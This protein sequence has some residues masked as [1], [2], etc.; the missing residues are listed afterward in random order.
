ML[1]LSFEEISEFTSM[2]SLG[3][4]NRELASKVLTHIRSCD[5]CREAVGGML[6]MTEIFKNAR[7]ELAEARKAQ[8]EK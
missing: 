4:T 1:H 5:K 3:G 7:E 8:R 2:D 6:N